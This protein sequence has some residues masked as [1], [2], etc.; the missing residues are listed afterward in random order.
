MHGVFERD[1]LWALKMGKTV[2]KIHGVGNNSPP[3]EQ[4]FCIK[5]IPG[6]VEIMIKQQQ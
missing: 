2:L 3:P 4:K 6:V 5:R 1:P